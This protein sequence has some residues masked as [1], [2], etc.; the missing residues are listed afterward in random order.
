MFGTRWQPLNLKTSDWS[1]LQGEMERAFEQLTG[2]SV[3]FARPTYPA[4]NMWEEE[5]KFLVE[6]ELPGL[7]LEGLEVF[8]N[9]DNQ[10]ILKGERK[11]P[12]VGEGSWLHQEREFG[13]FERTLR[14]PHEVDR[15]KVTAQFKHGIMTVTLPKKAELKPRKIQISES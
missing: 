5:D 6:A 12:E 10:L 4:V 15:D 8:V 11:G 13:S 9:S 2:A 3:Q 14:L 7:E 1:R